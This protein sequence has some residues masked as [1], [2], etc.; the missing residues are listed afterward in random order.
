MRT[1]IRLATVAAAAVLLWANA[2]ADEEKVPLDKL[3]RAVLDAVKAKFPDA[4]LLSASKE[5]EDDK[6]V[7]EVT[8]KYKDHNHDV[9]V[10]PEG[11]IL[12]IERE[13][14]SRDLPKVV[15]D[16]VEAKYPRATHKKAEELIKPDG[17]L[18]AYEVLLVTADRK[19]TVEVVLDPA[20]KILKEEKKETKKESK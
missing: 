7:F 5:K 20:G 16:A 14:A 11:K 18:H 15:A 2:G 9:T 19:L 12:G 3:P 8:L 4:K 6:T 10:D 13:I 1:L 17:K